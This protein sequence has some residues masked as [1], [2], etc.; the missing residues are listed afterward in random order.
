MIKNLLEISVIYDFNKA[1][2]H[3]KNTSPATS[4]WSEAT[5]KTCETVNFFQNDLLKKLKKIL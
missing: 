1:V 5:I 2:S 4:W 3:K